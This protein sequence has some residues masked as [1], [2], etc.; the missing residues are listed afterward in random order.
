MESLTQ[1]ISHLKRSGLNAAEIG[2][3]LDT[4][5]WTVRRIFSNLPSSPH[6][7]AHEDPDTVE[8]PMAIRVIQWEIF[9]PY[10]VSLLQNPHTTTEDKDKV[11][12]I[13]G[14]AASF[15]AEV[16]K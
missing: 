15:L 14:E 1:Q 2:R 13:L 16:S 12:K 10:A 5:Y 9:V 11:A 7:E 6:S 8:I 4:S 3:R